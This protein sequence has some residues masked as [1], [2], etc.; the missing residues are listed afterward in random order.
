MKSPQWRRKTHQLYTTTIDENLRSLS[1]V[2]Q[3][4]SNKLKWIEADSVKNDTDRE[5][6]KYAS[7]S[8]VC[9]R[10]QYV[11]NHQQVI[12]CIQI[13]SCT[14]LDVSF[15]FRSALW[16]RGERA[17]MLYKLTTWSFLTKH[18]RSC[19]CFSFESMCVT[20]GINISVFF[21]NS[22]QK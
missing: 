4:R 5:T 6:K 9:Y 8:G 1:N 16:V 14:W 10:D 13:V 20:N 7:R 3:S 18:Q 2:V 11:M 15:S 12:I 17:L 22:K 21:F 19:F